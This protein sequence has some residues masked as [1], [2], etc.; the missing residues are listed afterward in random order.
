M[1]RNASCLLLL[2]CFFVSSGCARRTDASVSGTGT[3]EL[4]ET[5]ISPVESG[6][7]MRLWVEEGATVRAGDTLATLD[8]PTLPTDVR[9]RQARVA[10]A[11]AEVRDL[12]RGARPEEIARAQ[13]ELNA[14]T[15]EAERAER[16]FAR[17]T[18]LFSNGVISAQQHDALRAAATELAGR[19][20]AAQH[21][22]E[23]LRAGPRPDLLRAARARLAEATASL[24]AARR[25]TN[26]LTLVAPSAG[27]VL[28]RYAEV[29]ELVSAHQ[30][31][32]TLAD[33]THPWVRIYVNQRD[34]PRVHLGGGAEARIDGV[35]DHPYRGRI[36]SISTKAEFTPRVALTEDERADMLFGVKIDLEDRTGALKA[37]LPVTVRINPA[38]VLDTASR[39][40][41][42]RTP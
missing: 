35:P 17:S 23:L 24:A 32:V 8:S 22:L 4:L 33:A 41:A 25:A 26:E 36:A 13:S 31:V 29:G 3:V 15:A 42:P 39:T 38:D 27:I 6:R 34:L 37:G 30:P 1:R 2:T 40:S 19:R 12:E 5:D 14:A 10:E 11:E 16:D 20:A 18:A 9:E 28:A 7:L 21:T